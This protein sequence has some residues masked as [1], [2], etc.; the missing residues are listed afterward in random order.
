MSAQPNRRWIGHVDVA[1]FV[2]IDIDLSK[3]VNFVSGPVFIP[4]FVIDE[5]VGRIAQNPPFSFNLLQTWTT[6]AGTFTTPG[7][8]F[9][10]CNF[11]PHFAAND[12]YGWVIVRSRRAA[13]LFADGWRLVL[14]AA[15]CCHEPL[16]SSRAAAKCHSERSEGSSSSRP[17]IFF[18]VDDDSSLRSE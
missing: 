6:P 1:V 13:S 10:M 18:R 7:R 11:L 3:L 16:M 2:A 5:P 12:M 14:L 9:V 8:Y 15:S 17:S 4:S